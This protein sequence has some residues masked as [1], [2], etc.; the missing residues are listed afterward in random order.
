MILAVILAVP[1]VRAAVLDW[2]RIGAVRI[3]LIQPSPTPVPTALPETP[4]PTA[5]PSPTPL[6]S[7]LDLSG[8]T[9][10]ADARKR[11]CGDIPYGIT[12]RL[13]SCNAH[14]R[15]PATSASG[16]PSHDAVPGINDVSFVGTGIGGGVMLPLMQTLAM[17]NVDPRSR[18]RTILRVQ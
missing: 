9:S 8:E 7:V 11:A 17:Q 16:H 14:G 4:A 5:L 18:T 3:F 2:I 10:L 1:P 15:K 6:P 12:T 13:T